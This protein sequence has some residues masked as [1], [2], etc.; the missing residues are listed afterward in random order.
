M[1]FLTN[2]EQT[3]KI[4]IAKVRI[5]Q[6]MKRIRTLEAQQEQACAPIKESLRV[7]NMRHE[8]FEKLYDETKLELGKVKDTFTENE[9]L[10]ARINDLEADYQI[11]S[12]EIK[13]LN[14]DVLIAQDL[15]DK[16]IEENTTLISQIDKF[17]DELYLLQKKYNLPMELTEEKETTSLE[18]IEGLE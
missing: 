9:K 11:F 13:D 4:T 14:R 16:A 10:R 2:T 6:M 18:I 3:K 17:T 15:T 12:D 8:V 7:A 5:K 1:N